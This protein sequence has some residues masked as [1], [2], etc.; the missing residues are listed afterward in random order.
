MEATSAVEKRQSRETAL[1][2]LARHTG[3]FAT[4]FSR[5]AM[6]AVIMTPL[7]LASFLTI[8]IPMRTFD[9][10][11]GGVIEVRP[12][13]WL[14]YGG[15]IIGL[16]PL[17]AILYA[18]KY[19]ADEASRAVTASWGL[20]AII[21]FAELSYLAPALEDGD[22]PGV[23]FTV[24]FV[25]SAMATQYI[26]ANVYDVAR[27]GGQWWRA[28]L[29]GALGGYFIFA[30]IYFPAAYWGTGAPWLNWMVGD[31]AI[32]MLMAFAFLPVYGMLRRTLRPKGGFGGQ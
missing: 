14:T 7:L 21:V 22:M 10:L 20:A 19:G 28:P 5:M 32:K 15:F 24:V 26:A 13:N 1:E 6:L 25:A 17:I 16:A 30:V 9:G 29:Y 2:R 18:R 4:A 8:D 31:L 12:S 23:R 3:E 27:G 11:F